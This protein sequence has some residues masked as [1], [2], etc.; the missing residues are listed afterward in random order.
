M[1]NNYVGNPVSTWCKDL[2]RLC[3]LPDNTK[4][5]VFCQISG[6]ME[7]NLLL[8]DINTFHLT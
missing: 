7:K 1:Q 8:C 2:G 5:S 6:N 3:Y 4:L